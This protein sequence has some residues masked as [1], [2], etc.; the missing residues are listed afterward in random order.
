MAAGNGSITG[1]LDS[2][3]NLPRRIHFT[4]QTVA[5]KGASFIHFSHIC[6]PIYIAYCI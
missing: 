4:V 6:S 2:E 1:V 3:G 5:G